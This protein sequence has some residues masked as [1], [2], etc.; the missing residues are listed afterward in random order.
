MLFKKCYL[1]P[2]NCFHNPV[3]GRNPQFWK[4]GCPNIRFNRTMLM[5]VMMSWGWHPAWCPEGAQKMLVSLLA[6]LGKPE[7]V[8]SCLPDLQTEAQAGPNSSPPLT[9]TCPA[10]VCS[11]F[12]R[13]MGTILGCDLQVTSSPGA[14]PSL[15]GEVMPCPR[16]AVTSFP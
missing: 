6:P 14:S 13:G 11:A 16:D 7:P 15:R 3:M 1:S 12:S 8:S 10:G 9:Q 4:R 2:T 5:T